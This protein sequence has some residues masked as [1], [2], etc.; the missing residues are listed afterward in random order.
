MKGMTKI[1]GNLIISAIAIMLIGTGINAYF[2]D[3]E[4]GYG[5]T[6]SAGTLDLTVDGGNANV[7][8]WSV[9]NLAPGSQINCGY[10]IY[11][12]KN[13]GS[14]AGYLDLEN[15]SVTEGGGTYTEPEGSSGDPTNQ[16]NLSMLMDIQYLFIDV[17]KNGW[18]S[19]G[20]VNMYSGKPKNFPSSVDLNYKLN[21]GQE[22]NVVL[23]M[24]WFSHAGTEDNKG[25]GD[26]MTLNVGFE[27]GQ[28]TAQ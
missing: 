24:N 18:W 15:C 20:D 25:Q 13:V 2:S 14:L 5:N 3:M 10:G 9:S 4:S 26:T 27:L 8:K 19:T 17:D 23:I 28:T 1:V 22:I 21:P 6:F 7:V 12:L 11:K 16:G